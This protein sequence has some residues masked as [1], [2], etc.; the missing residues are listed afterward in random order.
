M[1]SRVMTVPGMLRRRLVRPVAW[2]M[3]TVMAVSLMQ[4]TAPPADATPDRPGRPEATDRKPPPAFPPLPVKPRTPASGATAAPPVKVT[5]PTPATE[6]IAV[7]TSTG[8]TV[9]GLAV[10]VTVPG[11]QRSPRTTDREPSVPGKVRVQVLDRAW[12]ARA[13]VNGPVFRVSRSDG[14]EDA[15]AIRFGA[16][17]A[18]IA[19]AY[20]GDFGARLRLVRLPECAL[21]TPDRPDCAAQSLPTVNDGENRTVSADLTTPATGNALLALTATDSSAQGSYAATS[22][23]PSSK[24]SVAPSTGGFSWSYPMRTPPVPG[25][26]GPGTALSYSSQAV[27][28]RTTTTNNQGSWI[29]EGFTYEP[30]Y[31][32]RR[33]KPCADDGQTQYADQCWAYDNATIL[34]NGKST[35]LVK[36]GAHTWR[37]ADDD[38]SKVERLRGAV[39]GDS[40][41]PN[42]GD[43]GDTGEHWR[44]TTPEGTQYYFGLNRLPGWTSGKEE[45]SSTWTV[46]IYGDD[47]DE[48]CKKAT[49]TESYCDQGWRWNLDYVKDRHGNVTSYFYGRET[50]HYARG[51]RTDVNGVPYHRGGWLK[52]IDYGQRDGA[53][54]TSNAPAR[55]QFGTDERCLPTTGVDC[56]PAD[57]TD[58]TASHWPDVPFDRNCAAN[59]HCRA[60]QITPTFWTRKRLTTITTEIRGATAWIPVDQWKLG[61]IFLDNS[62]GSRSLWLEK[63]THTGLVNGSAAMPVVKLEAQQLPNRIDRTGDFIA[64]LIRPRM[65][66]IYTDTG[67]QIDILYED[68]DCTESTLPTEGNSTR[69]CFPVKWNPLG[70]AG[71]TTDWFHKYV[72][73]EVKEV[74]RT[75]A[76]PNMVTQ[77][78]YLDGAAWRHAEPDGISKVEDQTWSE[79]RGYGRVQ[80]IRG[81]GAVMTTKDEFRY[82][83]GMHG[84]KSP[85]GGTRSVT[86][87]DST[88]ASYTDHDQLVGFQLEGTTFDGPTEVNK[89]I[90]T[91]WRYVSATESHPWGSKTA[92]FVNTATTRNF[93]ALAAGGW[94][95]TKSS[96]TFDS[97]RGRPI[98]TEHEGDVGK[99]GDESCVRTS[100]ADSSTVYLYALVSRVESVSVLCSATPDRST[101]VISDDRTRYDGNAFGVSPTLGN[102]TRTERLAS[103]DGTTAT[104]VRVAEGTFDQYGRPK[105]ATDAVGSVT[106]MTYT[107]TNGLT[108]TLVERNP[109]GHETTTRYAPAWGSPVSQSDP[110]DLLTE[111]QYDPLGRLTKVWLPDTSGVGGA[112][113]PNI[114]YTYLVRA[115]QPV[116]VKTEKRQ[117]DQSYSV[118]YTLYDGFLRP[119]Q[120]QNEGPTGTRMVAD[121]FYTGTGKLDRTYAT[122]QA[123]GA[124]SDQI[125]GTVLSSVERQ[126]KYLYDGADRVKAEVFIVRGAEKWRTTTTYGGDRVAVDPPQGGTPR[127]TVTNAL[128]Q[129]TELRQHKGA[130]PSTAYDTTT[131]T[132][133]PAGHLQTVTDPAGNVWRHTYDQRGRKT[134]SVDPDAGTSSFSYDDLD[135]LTS[136]TNGAGATVSHSFDLIGRKLATYEGSAATGEL[137]SDWTWDLELLGTLSGTNRYVDDAVY[138]TYYVGYDEFYRPHGTQ[139]Y[140]PPHAGAEL[141]TMYAFGTEYNPD[142]TVNAIGVSDGGGL[143]FESIA[144]TYDNLERLTAMEGSTAYLLSAEYEATGEVTRVQAPL[145]TGN[146]FAT[147]AYEEGTRRLSRHTLSRTS[148][149]TYDVDALY[150]YDPAGNVTQI[151]DTPGN[152]R[153]VQ[154]FTYDYLRRMTE[155]WTSASTATDPC[156]GGAATTGVGGIAPYRHSYTYDV[157]G[158]RKT[159]TQHAVGGSLLTE[160]EY[161]YPAPGQPRPH[162]LSQMTETT[163]Q[164]TRLHTYQYDNA[165]N[166]TTRTE[167]GEDQTLVW[168]AEG[169]LDSVTDA[170]GAK[171]SF[172]YDVDGSRILRKEPDATTLY[173]P[174]MEVR[175]NHTTRA[176]EGTHFYGLPGGGTMVRKLNGLHYVQPDHHGTGQATIDKTGAIV[177]RRSTPFGNPR[178]T[179]P[180]PGQWPTQKGFVGGN[181]DPTTGLINIGAREYDPKIGRFISVDPVIDVNDPQQMHGYAYANNSPA[182]FSDPTGLYHEEGNDG[183]GQQ[184]YQTDTGITVTGKPLNL[185]P[186]STTKRDRGNDGGNDSAAEAA[187]RE[188]QARIARAKQ[189]ILEAAKSLAKVAMDELGIT[190]ALNCLTK[191]DLDGC[192]NTAIDLATSF[193]GGLVAKFARKYGPP[194][195]WDDGVALGN[196][197]KGL[198]GDLVSGVRQLITAKSCKNSFLPGTL[199]LMADGSRKPI[200]EIT[201]GEQVLATDPET[202]ETVAKTVVATI[203]GDGE[204]HLVKVTIDLDG[205]AGTATASVVA[206]DNHPFWVPEL[207]Q[208]IDATNLHA[209]QLLQTSA[210]THVQI[211]SIARWTQPQ[212]VHNLTIDDIHTYYVM[213]GETPVL[214]HNCNFKPGVAD[215]K[216]DKHVLG[217]D[218]AGNATRKP[219]MSEYDYDGGFE[220]FVSDAQKLMCGNSCPAGARQ[221]VRSSD[222][223]I[224]RLDSSGRVGIRQGNVITTYFRPDDPAAYFAREAAR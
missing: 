26:G 136:T 194:W 90:T 1:F 99:T 189:K 217:L 42:V 58:A 176:T 160:R 128:G 148:G 48:P 31:I 106:H 193:V 87:S 25:G 116:A 218:D 132:Y 144:Y 186:A 129:V 27:D 147:Y 150:S 164:G 39:N 207:H 223:A 38:N 89:T 100:Y 4:V 20:G 133:T 179:Q 137:L 206:T 208:W 47:A 85:T 13:G 124:P 30:G 12:S 56:D 222:G 161:K 197:V 201:T 117:N 134:G 44:V 220:D 8:A 2:S 166:T 5:W 7:P 215:E 51:K 107:E 113:A 173:L 63:I 125:V 111:L 88:N 37:F 102:P 154:C 22:L 151:A 53:V 180:A 17:Y 43:A 75:G 212:Q 52:R 96:T 177:H 127:T 183:D 159:E 142:G 14:R 91:P 54:Y 16:G 82:F 200:E 175:L 49:F 66:T 46:P 74:D 109:L 69:R 198:L 108:T 211:T 23:A 18:G 80:V 170:A 115:D 118:Q 83:R 33:Y 203:T 143:P 131:Y 156:A 29:G 140:V 103:H 105:T 216:Y 92:A 94:R 71:Q 15:G 10:S 11:E 172:V 77:Y 167:V 169:N 97:V 196:K 84:D 145:G 32:E 28:G 126:T 174:G 61:H 3:A 192:L 157:V 72:V 114:K 171:T 146:V 120:I 78:D 60:D 64:P 162:T 188:R 204:K 95:Q 101:Q 112:A 130:D 141:A 153:D 184:G 209:G 210:G 213:A 158:N 165:G 181:L 199:V 214:V 182:T 191:G 123:A 45:T 35:E 149:P 104:Y 36:V 135:R 70:S 76:A 219:D 86:V 81:D 50:N 221:A 6:E 93:T 57:L 152:V 139:Y 24:W 68:P 34:I 224:I 79:W 98:R 59:T 110:N 9:G 21:S 19:G 195:K 187:E 65:S 168:D 73:A 138:S 41:S 155:A 62:D 205:E 119:R 202:G 40:G 121:T 185:P 122:Y 163:V 190:D 55:V 178:G 67:G